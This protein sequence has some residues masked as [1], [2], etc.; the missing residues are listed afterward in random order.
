MKRDSVDFFEVK[1]RHE[2]VDR[3]LHNWGLWVHGSRRSFVQPMFRYYR[4]DDVWEPPQIKPVVD[5]SDAIKMEKAVI[6]LPELHRHATQWCYVIKCT[7]I[8][9][10]REYAVTPARLGELVHEARAMLVNRGF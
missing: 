3:R 7:P 2:A 1:P 9:A 4:S 10:C 5:Q 6:A 8:K